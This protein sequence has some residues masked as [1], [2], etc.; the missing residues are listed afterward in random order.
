MCDAAERSSDPT[1]GQALA[2]INGDTLN[3]KLSAPEGTIFDAFADES[4]RIH[5]VAA[6]GV[7]GFDQVLGHRQAHMTQADKTDLGHFASGLRHSFAQP[8]REIGNKALGC[9][10]ILGDAR[11]HPPKATHAS[12]RTR[13]GITAQESR[14]RQPRLRPRRGQS[15]YAT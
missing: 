4:G 9:D 3:K 5:V 2:I 10:A 6:D 1:I 15:T 11:T 7:P 14:P 8:L 12:S 13:S